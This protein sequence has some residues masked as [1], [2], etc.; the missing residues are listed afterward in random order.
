MNDNMTT[1]K[2]CGK[3]IAKGVKKCPHCGKDQRN[4]FMKHKIISVI[5]II[6]IL[7]IVGKA[8]AGNGSNTSSDTKK[9]ASTAVSSKSTKTESKPKDDKKYSYSKFMQITMGMTYEQVK[10]ILGEGTEQSSTGDGDTK[11]ITYAWKNYDGTNISVEIQ[12]GKVVNKAQAMLQSMDA[13]VTMEKYN[14][15]N[16]GMTYDQ[17]KAVLGEGQLVSQTDLLGTKGEIYE[18]INAG[19]PNMNVTFQDGKVQ[20]KTQMELK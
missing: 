9:E 8:L 2:T 14:K 7:C 3:E 18:W 17:V 4:F 11:T 1:C 15:I 13:N 20:A 10:G 5:G 12:G 19:G 6:I 16:N